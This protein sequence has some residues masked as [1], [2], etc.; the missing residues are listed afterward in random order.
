MKTSKTLFLNLIF[1]DLHL[2]TYL[3]NYFSAYYNI[4]DKSVCILYTVAECLENI[5]PIEINLNLKQN[6]KFLFMKI[7]HYF[8]TCLIIITMSFF[9]RNIQM[10][11]TQ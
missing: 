4:A 11:L 5:P 6:K 10:K 2:L 1:F 7:N 9:I 8:P 3:D